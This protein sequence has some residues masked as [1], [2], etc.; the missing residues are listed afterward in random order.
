MIL[1][2][3]LIDQSK[4]SIDHYLLEEIKKVIGLKKDELRGKI[5]TQF[6]GFRPKA[7]YYLID[8]GSED[9]NAKGTKKCEVKRI[10]T[11]TSYINCLLNNEIILGKKRFKSEAHNLHTKEINKIKLHH[12]HLVQVL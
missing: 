1:K 9:K 10:F 3:D 5:M 12:T 6:V 7:N 4:K 8:D 2:K 11:F